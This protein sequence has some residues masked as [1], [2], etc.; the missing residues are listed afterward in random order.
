MLSKD[1]VIFSLLIL[2]DIAAGGDAMH[3]DEL[4]RSL[5]ERDG[6]SLGESKQHSLVAIK[7]GVALSAYDSPLV[8]RPV[9]AMQQAQTPMPSNVRPMRPP[10][11][12]GSEDGQ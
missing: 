1:N 5:L 6:W 10:E 11:V 12:V 7:D 8:Q 3:L 9:Q 4:L 2:N